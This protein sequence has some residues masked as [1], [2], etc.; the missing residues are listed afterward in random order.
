[1]F[2]SSR[3]D[4]I[5][6]VL[7]GVVDDEEVGGDC[8]GLPDRTTLRQYLF[9]IFRPP[10]MLALFR[11]SRPDYIETRLGAKA[12]SSASGLFRSSRPDYIE[13]AHPKPQPKKGEPLFR[14]SRPDYIETRNSSNLRISRLFHCSGLPD[15]T[16]L[17]RIC[18]ES[19]RRQYRPLFRSS[20]PDYIETKN[21][22]RISYSRKRRIVP[23]FQTG[24]H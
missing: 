14:S 8:S 24:L 21:P 11:S 18:P 15:R 1:M 20:R 5:E 10:A 4:Y 6:T 3:P 22:S 19:S 13:T 9:V 7:D 2:R 17:R 12:E 23:V 16:T